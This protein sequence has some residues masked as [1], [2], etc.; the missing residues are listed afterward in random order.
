MAAV[1]ARSDDSSIGERIRPHRVGSQNLRVK[2]PLADAVVVVDWWWP[3][4]VEIVAQMTSV[5]VAV[6]VRPVQEGSCVGECFS[7]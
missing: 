7:V 5:V 2:D 6:V 3:R 1:G 4:F